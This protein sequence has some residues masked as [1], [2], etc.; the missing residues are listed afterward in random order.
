MTNYQSLDIVVIYADIVGST[1]IVGKLPKR[2][3]PMFYKIFSNEIIRILNDFGGTIY[4]S[5]G[6]EIIGIFPIPKE[7]W[8]PIIDDSM[9]CARY[10]RDVTKNV[11]GPTAESIGLPRIQCRIG[12][13]YGET[14]IVNIGV[15]GIFLSA[16]ILGDVMNTAAKI[17]GKAQ[18]G[19]IA[20]GENLRLLLHAS[21]KMH[22]K[23]LAP[24]KK[25]DFE[26]KVYWL[27]I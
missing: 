24:L 6:D 11:I 9:R 15:E 5:V 14:Q 27:A 22:C 2:Q 3:I 19:E 1:R 26:Y 7:S 20:I 13:D 8:I 12:A 21:Y 25:D 16:E 10:V 4:K 17:R 23:E 18:P